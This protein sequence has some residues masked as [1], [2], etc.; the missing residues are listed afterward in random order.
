LKT[1][2]PG[3][4]AFSLR[5]EREKLE[6]LAIRLTLLKT[7]ETEVRRR[8]VDELEASLSVGPD[9][10]MMPAWEQ[11]RHMAQSGISF[12]AHT[13]T[14]PILPLT[15]AVEMKHEI[16]D[17]KA[18]IEAQVGCGVR[19]FAYPNDDFCRA[20]VEAVEAAGFEAASA[21]SRH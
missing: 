14:H 1:G 10:G 16:A 12:G 15:E 7:C 11:C 5:S 9:Q 18:S 3:P 2:R 13:L 21:G 20:T 8:A 17:S 6:A 4:R 19:Y